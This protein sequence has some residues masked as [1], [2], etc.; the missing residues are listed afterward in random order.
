MVLLLASWGSIIGHASTATNT[1]SAWAN[2][3]ALAL[4]KASGLTPSQQEPNFLS[5]LD[6]ELLT[7]H[8]VA[9]ATM[10]TGC[11]TEAA[12]GLVDTD[13]DTVIFN[14]T[15]EGLPLQP[16][17]N[18]EVLVPWPK[19]LDMLALDATSTGGSYLS[20]YKNPLGSLQDQRNIVG[21]LSSKRLTAPPELPLLGTDGQHLVANAQTLAFSDSGSWLVAE[22]LT[23]S[24]LRINLATLAVTPF[25]PSFAALGS[26]G[27]FKSQ[28]A[29]SSDGRY[30][31]VGNEVA[32]SF[33]VYDLASC[34]AAQA[35]N[36]PSYDYRTFIKKQLPGLQ[37]IRHVRF[38]NEGLISF[39]ATSN[40]SNESGSYLL[41]PTSSIE[42][43]TDYI[44]LGDSYTS[45]EGAFDYR[46]GTD[47]SDNHCHLSGQSYPMLLT[48][49]L[50][51]PSGGHSVACSGAEI[52]DVASVS[53]N[54]HGQVAHSYG[55][56]E[57]QKDQPALLASVEVNYLP[58]YIAQHRFVQANQPKVITVSVGGD[59]V[60]F[61]AMVETCVLPHISL[62]ASDDTCFNT[63]EDRLELL[64]TID[65]TTKR[66]Q[67]LFKQLHAESPLSSIFVVG[68]P[69]IIS[70]NGNC[71]LNV[72]LDQSER[73]FA[74]EMTAYINRAIDQSAQKAGVQ[75]V[76]IS[77]A[78]LGHRL[79]ETAS[80]NVAVNGLTAGKDAGVLGINFLGKESYHPNALG[81]RLIEQAILHG[82]HN[83]TVSAPSNTPDPSQS[84]L[85]KPK[86]NRPIV[87][88]VPAQITD[89]KLV[90]RG[91]T[92]HISVDG[93]AHGLLPNYSYSI[94][95]GQGI[96]IGSLSSGSDGSLD[97]DVNIPADETPGGDSLDISG[98]NQSGDTIV[99]TQPIDITVSDSDTDGDGITNNLDSCPTLPNSGQDTDQDGTDDACDGFISQPPTSGGPV[100]GA[101]NSN[102]SGAGSGSGSSS[103]G[104]PLRPVSIKS[105]ASIDTARSSASTGTTTVNPQKLKGGHLAM[106]VAITG[107]PR[108][109][110][111]II[112]W[113]QWCILLI[114]SWWLILLLVW[115]VRSLQLAQRPKS[116]YAPILSLSKFL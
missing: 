106:P 91:S 96:P 18:Q 65:S 20:L 7:Y 43:L 38:V 16:Y 77:Q 74:R 80:Y 44:G 53:A 90:A 112:A 110:L 93:P 11:F 107:A 88:R 37:Y 59:D 6:C 46:A 31:A 99:I 109:K 108:E 22:S 75:Y 8:L 76:D 85:N 34:S 57:L 48:Q 114:L 12:F 23:G 72:H 52:N 101:G 64:K 36:C 49:D 28:V 26:P 104:V 63:Y 67:A 69:D 27:L 4:R 25:A 32:D 66:W 19:A 15:D 3:A 100:A 42:S 116:L 87:T 10:H 39:E 21:Q 68:Y 2:P 70:D 84:L 94:K 98:D 33:K 92:V 9:D 102:P 86:T 115:L 61:G 113:L 83:L 29:I 17:S 79:C 60:G 105:V 73:E 47:T 13:S 35:G 71:A 62:H 103:T 40:V 54:Y 97:G 14:G 56:S 82:S 81:Q 89:K 5:N 24:F 111:R 78:L 58:G 51:G 50:F 1:D 30:V 41:A 95:T 45:G 55:Y